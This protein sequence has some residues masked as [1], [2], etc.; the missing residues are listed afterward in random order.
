MLICSYTIYSIVYAKAA[1]PVKSSIQ[2]LPADRDRLRPVKGHI[3]MIKPY[4]NAAMLENHMN[5]VLSA[6][7]F[8]DDPANLIPQATLN[9]ESSINEGFRLSRNIIEINRTAHNN[10]IAT[11]KQGQN[12]FG[13][14]ILNNAITKFLACPAGVAGFDA[15]ICKLDEFTAS[16]R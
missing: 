13:H 14:I 6:A 11:Q 8:G 3:L 5:S 10:A 1:V 12:I 15:I 7:L 16:N 2:A 4:F 9:T